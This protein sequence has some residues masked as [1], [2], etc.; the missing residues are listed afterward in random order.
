MMMVKG[1]CESSRSFQHFDPN[2]AARQLD[3]V[4]AAIST[5]GAQRPLRGRQPTIEDLERAHA[6]PP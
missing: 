2:L 5:P 4:R 3:L 6:L 1:A